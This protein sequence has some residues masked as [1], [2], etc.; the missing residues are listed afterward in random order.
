[1]PEPLPLHR[2]QGL[3][4]SCSQLKLRTSRSNKTGTVPDVIGVDLAVIHL[5]ITRTTYQNRHMLRKENAKPVRTTEA[6]RHVF[7]NN[8][9]EAFELDTKKLNKL[10]R[11]NKYRG[12][13]SVTASRARQFLVPYP[14]SPRRSLQLIFVSDGYLLEIA[15][16]AETGAPKRGAG[17]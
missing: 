15:V 2:A 14:C 6:S 12:P 7:P 4:L 16:M 8:L 1:M 10:P 17:A 13:R 5:N 9:F 11:Q 3:S